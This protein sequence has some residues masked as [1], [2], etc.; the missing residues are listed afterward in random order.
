MHFNIFKTS[1]RN[2][3]PSKVI[4][5]FVNFLTHE[6]IVKKEV[7]TDVSLMLKLVFSGRVFPR[8]KP[9]FLCI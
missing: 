4:L 6:Q 8:Q 5:K 7:N 1:F 2:N 3:S 9:S